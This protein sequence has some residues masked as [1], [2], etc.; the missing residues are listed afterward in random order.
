MSV[1]IF[2][3]ETDFLNCI[4][5]FIKYADSKKDFFHLT[6][7]LHNLDEVNNEINFLK[8]QHILCFSGYS[9]KRIIRV[10]VMNAYGSRAIITYIIKENSKRLYAKFHHDLRLLE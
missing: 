6:I 8:K 7:K 5:D 1:I 9:T 10:S 2:D 3:N 4:E